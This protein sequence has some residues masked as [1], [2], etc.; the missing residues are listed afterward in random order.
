MY[1]LAE[2]FALYIDLT[3]P[4]TNYGNTLTIINLMFLAAIETN[5]VI[6]NLIKAKVAS[7][8]GLQLLMPM[9]YYNKLTIGAATT[10]NLTARYN[11]AHGIKLKKLY[12]SPYNIAEGSFTSF[13]NDNMAGAKVTQF[14]TMIN[15]MRTS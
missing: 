6:E 5:P 7:A 3:G 2:K 10:Q 4:S 13:D 1:I 15:N 9:V 12:W 11:R 8:E 14:Y